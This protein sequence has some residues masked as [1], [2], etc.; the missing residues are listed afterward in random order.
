MNKQILRLAI[1]NIISN[2]TIPLLGLINIA[3]AGHLSNDAAIGAVGIGASIFGFI[4]W[5]CSFLRMGT[6]GLTAQAF[7]ARD[8]HE[9]TNLLV[10][11]MAV[12]IGLAALLLLFHYPIGNISIRIMGGSSATSALVAEY[13]FVRIWAA[14]AT[15]SLYAL[16]GWF[17]GMQNAKTPMYISIVINLISILFGYLFVFH[18][19]MGIKGI[20]WST[21]IAQYSGLIL[22]VVFWLRYYR[23][24]TK[25]ISWKN[26]ISLKPML[27][28]FNVNKDIFLRTACNVFVYTFFTKA[29]A[30]YGDVTLATN[31]ILINLFT[32]YSYVSDGFAYAAEALTG[33][34]TGARDYTSLKEAVK[35]MFVWSM[36]I[37]V[38]YTAI[39]ASFTAEIIQLFAPQDSPVGTS[40]LEAARQQSIWIILVPLVGFAPFLMDGML[41]G[42]T[43]TRIMRN[44]MFFSAVLFFALYFALR[45]HWDSNALWLSFIV[46]LSA[47]GI[48]QL[49][50]TDKLRI[51]YKPLPNK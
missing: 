20:A 38:V 36:V 25:Y 32:L 14:P 23:R 42:A 30:A 40:I 21:V 45:N 4:Y 19:D 47:R 50:M 31:T 28:F 6:S 11:A 13:F 44:S 33:R 41:I 46:F 5:N 10:R 24:L 15:I 43:R 35:K 8:L 17:I 1:P 9:A 2:I 22:A 34:F 26:S 3:I 39:F 29:S 37:A 18:F 48:L 16:F 27:R 7:G 51:L 12:A 49:I